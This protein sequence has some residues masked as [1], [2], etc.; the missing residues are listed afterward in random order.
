[1]TWNA[2]KTISLADQVT[3]TNYHQPGNVT[4]AN[5]GL[6]LTTPA[7]AG[8]ETINYSGALTP[9]AAS[10]PC[11]NS[12]GI[13]Y[14]YFGL[15]FLTNNATVSWDASSRATLALTYRYQSRAIV[16]TSGT[17][18]NE[19]LVGVDENGAILNVAL[20]PTTHWTLNGS[21]D[22]SY[23]DNA[24]TPV[25]PRQ[26]KHYRVHTSY[27]PKPWATI[28]GAYNDLERH[29]NT[30]N[31]GTTNLDGPLQHVDHTRIGSLGLSLAP[32]EHYAFDFSYSYSDVYITSN[33]CYL[34]RRGR[35]GHESSELRRRG[36]GEHRGA[37]PLPERD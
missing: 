26:L 14:A 22:F 11:G 9:G 31:T 28:F 12:A 23:S 25:S 7:T 13:M 30:Y 29:N 17:G 27:R 4:L 18:P 19:N 33:I 6:A 15:R 5:A 16:Q 24:F 37:K 3:Y 35:H 34:E 1:M 32:N 20:R 21:A 2:T 8:N 36:L 10:L